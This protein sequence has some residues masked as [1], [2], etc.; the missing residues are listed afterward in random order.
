LG[1]G[2]AL[3]QAEPRRTLGRLVSPH[4]RDALHRPPIP[5]TLRDG[6]ELRHD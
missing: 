3:D 6:A 2:A 5:R 1:S 4:V